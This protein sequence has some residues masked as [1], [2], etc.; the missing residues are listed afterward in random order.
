MINSLVEIL[1]T[2][3]YS[4]VIANG[5]DI[6]KFSLRGV[7][8]LYNL[9]KDEPNF[10]DGAIIAD[11][12]VGKGAA[13]LMVNGS[14]HELYTHIISDGAYSLLTTNNIKVGYGNIVPHIINRTNTGWCPIEKLCKGIDN[15]TEILEIIDKFI[16]E[17]K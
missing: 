11:K 15:I 4:C 2:G 8:D 16:K 5:D 7:A 9:T 3:N 1:D 17:Q 6:R 14:I 12:V 10:L 13:A